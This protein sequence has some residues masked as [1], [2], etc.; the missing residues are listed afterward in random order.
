MGRKQQSTNN[1]TI[2]NDEIRLNYS[3]QMRLHNLPAQQD[4]YESSISFKGKKEIVQKVV[5][6]ATEK[7]L[8]GKKIFL[9]RFFDKILDAMDYETCVQAGVAAVV[10]M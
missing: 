4:S 8:K 6:K 9:S 3:E 5:N 10:C 1:V 2:P 7:E